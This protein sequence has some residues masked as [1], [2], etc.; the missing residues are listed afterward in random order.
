MTPKFHPVRTSLLAPG[1]VLTFRQKDTFLLKP[2][3]RHTRSTCAGGAS[4]VQ[5]LPRCGA[6][7]ESADNRKRERSTRNWRSR[8]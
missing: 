2:D 7:Q 8:R 6:E 1:L 5:R 4:L 3:A